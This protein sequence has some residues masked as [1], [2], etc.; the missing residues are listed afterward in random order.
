[1][2]STP[3][4]RHK[5][6]FQSILLTLLLLTLLLNPLH[7]IRAEEE[8]ELWQTP[9]E[10]PLDED[11]E[12]EIAGPTQPPI[13]EEE[14]DPQNLPFEAR[15]DRLSV[16]L[17]YDGNLE[18]TLSEKKPYFLCHPFL[19]DEDSFRLISQLLSYPLNLQ[20]DKFQLGLLSSWEWSEDGKQ[21]SLQLKPDLNWSDGSPISSRDLL[22]SL[23]TLMKEEVNANAK[24]FAMQI[25]GAKEAILDP[26][27]D[28]EEEGAPSQALIKIKG[29]ET[30]DDSSLVIRFKR[31]FRKHEKEILR[32]PVLP[33]KSWYY[34]TPRFWAEK[35]KNDKEPAALA[36]SYKILPFRKDHPNELDLQSLAVPGMIQTQI[37]KIKLRFAPIN[38]LPQL[39]LENQADLALLPPL[40]QESRDLLIADGYKLKSIPSNL[41]H[42]LY[43]NKKAKENPFRDPKL[44][45]VLKLLLNDKLSLAPSWDGMLI[46]RSEEDLPTLPF[47]QDKSLNSIPKTPE[48]IQEKALELLLDAGYQSPLHTAEAL[49]EYEEK[50]PE[51]QLLPLPEIILAYPLNE[52][53]LD[54][55]A[56]HISLS[57]QSLGFPARSFAVA[58]EDIEEGSELSEVVHLILDSSYLAGID[59]DMPVFPLFSPSLTF[60][61]KRIEGFQADSLEAFT[62]SIL[63]SLPQK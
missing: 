6:I 16:L 17:P 32:L 49:Q 56:Y 37:P 25:E 28:P 42:L 34:A 1:M 45:S 44:S 15:P 7:A 63:W 35:K 51:K 21:L 36:G 59:A 33:M 30:P 46:S 2:R 3:A 8:Q 13:E 52:V 50:N 22:F 20:N 23:Q 19:A 14:V 11:E 31:D 57:L 47:P 43:L 24:F 55:V 9:S 39:L 61:W 48:E 58:P 41:H 38:L 12:L 4:L 53:L 27:F 18:E 62:T 54:E 29:L 40:S 26:Q 5:D 60:A 10:L